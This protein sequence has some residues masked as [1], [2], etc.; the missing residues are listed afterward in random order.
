MRVNTAAFDLNDPNR[1][2]IAGDSYYSYPYVS[3]S[4]DAGQ[5]WQKLCCTGIAGSVLALLPMQNPDWFFCGTTTGLYKST[6]AGAIWTRKG[7]M[8]NVRSVLLDPNNGEVFYCGT[9]S[10]VY[11]SVDGLGESWESINAGLGMTDVLS[12]A[13]R[14]GGEQVLFAG[15][16]GGSV[17][18]LDVPTAVADRSLPACSSQLAFT[19][20]PNPCSGRALL[21]ARVSSP[22]RVT[23]S[24]ITGRRVWTGSLTPAEN[25][26][27]LPRLSAG[28]YLVRLVDGQ[29]TATRKLV[30]QQ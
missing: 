9:S 6:D 13:M 11:R 15:T 21:S 7:T 8:N 25:S 29:T 2:Y 14:L 23:V 30:V 4:T 24:D 10:G 22:S 20:S 5:T 3:R 28:V 19:L 17:Y 16:N 12:L 27:A 18:K 26:L 1:M